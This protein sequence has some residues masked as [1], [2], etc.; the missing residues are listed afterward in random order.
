MCMSSFCQP[1]KV[2]ETWGVA[3]LCATFKVLKLGKQSS[4][5]KSKFDFF[6]LLVLG[7]MG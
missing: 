1:I 4:S 6:I 7:K 2:Y 3:L 5:G